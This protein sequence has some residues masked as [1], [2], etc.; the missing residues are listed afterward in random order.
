M[1]TQNRELTT[2][3]RNQ[4]YRIVIDALQRKFNNWDGIIPEPKFITGTFITGVLE[5]IICAID[6]AMEE[7]EIPKTKV[8][9]FE[10]LGYGRATC[11]IFWDDNLA[12]IETET[13]EITVFM[14]TEKQQLCFIKSDSE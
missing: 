4:I 5:E 12:R 2:E 10:E 6:N 13:G 1:E 7:V 3:E 9:P 14:D 8:L 11:G